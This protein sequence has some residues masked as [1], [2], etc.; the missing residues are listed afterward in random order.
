MKNL[1][2]FR[3]RKK[4]K[5]PLP[6]R[7]VFL[8]SLLIFSFL[9]VQGLIIVEAG[10]R[11]TLIEIAK[12]ETQRVGTLAINDAISKKVIGDLNVDEI[13]EY[14]YDSNGNIQ[15]FQI[16][17]SIY[18]KVQHETVKRVQDYLNDI[19]HGRIKDYSLPTDVD[20]EREGATFTEDGIIHMIP[21]GQATNNAL[22]AHLGPR[23]PVRLSTIGEVK[24]DFGQEIVNTGI[25]NTYLS[26]TVDIEADVQVVIPFATDQEVVKTSI[27]V[28]NVWLSGD[29]P[30]FYSSGGD[31]VT[32]AIIAPN[33]ID[34]QQGI[35]GDFSD[36]ELPELPSGNN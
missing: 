3:P 22:L 35:Q 31:G 8:I 18:L 7:F 20:I 30:Q 17:N 25:N 5:G 11:P 28:A 29:V 19:E 21:L 34:Q 32:P 6:F 4:R 12:T 10:I 23:V 2:T 33:D 24:A 15:S 9:T 26:I 1:R 27:P 13:V 36:F 14:Q 16:N